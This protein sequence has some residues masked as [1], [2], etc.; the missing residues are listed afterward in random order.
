MNHSGQEAP[1]CETYVLPTVSGIGAI[2]G[3]TS[4]DCGQSNTLIRVLS[5]PTGGVTSS[6][7]GGNFG[8]ASTSMQA[9][10]SSQTARGGSSGILPEILPPFVVLYLHF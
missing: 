10:S 9:G 8:S 1:G 4:Y 2:D 6:Q 3:L 5:T 7:F